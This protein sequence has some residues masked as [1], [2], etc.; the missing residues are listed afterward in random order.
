M[1]K[2]LRWLTWHIMTYKHPQTSANDMDPR[3]LGI[4]RSFPFEFRKNAT[5]SR[6]AKLAFPSVAH[7]IWPSSCWRNRGS[8][9]L[10]KLSESVRF[11]WHVP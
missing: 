8:V 5:H 7:H 2:K 4:S 3:S 11:L 6:C 10:R 1:E 9:C